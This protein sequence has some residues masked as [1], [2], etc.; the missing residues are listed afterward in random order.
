MPKNIS[1]IR[2]KYIIRPYKDNTF[3]LL[4]S[5]IIYNSLNDSLKIIANDIDNKFL[6]YIEKLLRDFERVVKLIQGECTCIY[7]FISDIYKYINN[8]TDLIKVEE[9]IIRLSLYI[10]SKYDAINKWMDHIITDIEKSINSTFYKEFESIAEIYN[11][12][13]YVGNLN[14]AIKAMELQKSTRKMM[15]SL[16]SEYGMAM[17]D[18]IYDQFESMFS[19]FNKLLEYT[20]EVTGIDHLE[21]L[22]EVIKKEALIRKHRDLEK[23]LDDNE[24][25]LV[26]SNGSHNIYKHPETG[27]VRIIPHRRGNH[28]L[29]VKTAKSIMY[30]VN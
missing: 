28:M 16:I 26:R 18:N 23:Y 29:A 3:M 15:S 27:E 5:D 4:Y 11:M 17:E 21:E 20:V 12:N 30:G 1:R 6:E 10:K 13:M 2:K 8:N 14:V 22:S 7:K 24:F 9:V 25:K 19:T